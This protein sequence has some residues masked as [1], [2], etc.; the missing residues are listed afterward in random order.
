[1]GETAIAFLC[2]CMLWWQVVWDEVKRQKDEVLARVGLLG[3]QQDKLS[4][5]QD[6]LMESHADM[7]LE[8]DA[9]LREVGEGVTDVRFATEDIKSD[10]NKLR[11]EQATKF[12]RM[13][14]GMYQANN[15]SVVWGCC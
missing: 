8:M 3:K 11:T 4:S 15:V 10:V 7:R 13:M 2:M 14:D 1:M 9:R 12:D 6:Q 5:Q